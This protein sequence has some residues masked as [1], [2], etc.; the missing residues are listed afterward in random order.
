MVLWL[1][2]PDPP[3]EFRT[4]VDM[5]TRLFSFILILPLLVLSL[6]CN[7]KDAPTEPTMEGIFTGTLH[8]DINPHIYGQDFIDTVQLSVEGTHFAFVTLVHT[9]GNVDNPPICSAQ[10]Q[11]AGFGARTAIFSPTVIDTVVC[12][13]KYVPTG[14]FSTTF[15]SDSLLMYRKSLI[16]QDTVIYDFKLA[17]DDQ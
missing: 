10:G 5:R 6:T 14:A 7:K 16:G 12:R 2:A 15:R 9:D 8:F 1:T 3:E 17:V 11:V 4:G 13:A